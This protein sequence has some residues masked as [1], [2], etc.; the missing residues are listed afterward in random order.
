MLPE[1]ASLLETPSYKAFGLALA[2]LSLGHVF[3]LESIQSPLLLPSAKAELGDLLLCVLVCSRPYTEASKTLGDPE[4]AARIGTLAQT[5]ALTLSKTTTLEE[6]AKAVEAYLL[7]YLQAPPR[8]GGDGSKLKTPWQLF[9]ITELQR[10][11]GVTEQEAWNMPC[12]KAF[13]YYA[14]IAESAGDKSL[15]TEAEAQQ[16]NAINES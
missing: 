11:L 8:W 4:L 9:L 3:L 7:H 2:P 12:N 1:F 14:A 10:H 15:M 6:Q 5:W 16:V 13:A